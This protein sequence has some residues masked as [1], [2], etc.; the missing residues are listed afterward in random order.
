[1][2]DTERYKSIRQLFLPPVLSETFLYI[3]CGS[4]SH[5]QY[6]GTLW[7]N[8]EAKRSI[9]VFPN[10]AQMATNISSRTVH[11]VWSLNILEA[12]S[13][14]W[15]SLPGMCAVLI[16]IF[17]AKTKSQLCQAILFLLLHLVKPYLFTH[18]KAVVLSVMIP[19]CM[20]ISRVV[21]WY[22]FLFLW[23]SFEKLFL[24]IEN[25]FVLVQDMQMV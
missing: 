4:S 22:L 1:M 15:W 12:S 11:S 5:K 24:N 3:A 16:H 17:S 25:K 9:D 21:V 8:L 7:F 20:S 6:L 10:F 23:A 2:Y 18:T 14:S 13:A 19:I